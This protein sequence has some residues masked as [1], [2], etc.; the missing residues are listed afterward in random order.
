MK[1]GLIDLDEQIAEQNVPHDV[2][3]FDGDQRHDHRSVAPQAINKLPFGFSLEGCAIQLPHGIV[4]IGDLF[5]D[6]SHSNFKF[7]ASCAY[8]NS[9]PRSSASGSQIRAGAFPTDRKS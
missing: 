8:S 5:T 3:T 7:N 1:D 9:H 2:A 4:V 6:K